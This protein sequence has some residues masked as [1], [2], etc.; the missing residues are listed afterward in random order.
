MKI[1]VVIPVVNESERIA[2]LVNH[3]LRHGGN[4]LRE[5][6]V[7]DGG[8]L[9]DTPER[10][11]AAGAT[12]LCCSICTRAA[13]MNTGANA[14]AGDVLYFIH[15]DT[16]PPPSFADDIAESI[17]QGYIMGCYRYKF[18]SPHFLLKINA[19]FNRFQWLW[20]Q[21]GDKTFFIRKEVFRQLGG[22][23]EQHVIME[24]Y[25]FLRRAMPLYR[26]RIIPKYAIVSARK[27]ERNGWVRVQLA[28]IVTFN[29]WRLG[30]A[31]SY[32]K[33]LYKSMLK[34]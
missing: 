15:A 4:D 22:Y 16:L 11:M 31:P 30:V 2:S 33:R 21:G 29:L 17:R 5:I 13:Q 34:S 3:L 24:E 23:D 6:L 18:D 19:Y 28:N 9:D 12:L 10:A 32:L 26:L 1:S 25:D 7:V 20:G 27:Y 8:S 14:A